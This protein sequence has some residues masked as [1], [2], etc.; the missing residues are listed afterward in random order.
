VTPASGSPS[1]HHPFCPTRHRIDAGL[2]ARADVLYSSEIQQPYARRPS[3]ARICRRTTLRHSTSNTAAP[4]VRDEEVSGRP[5][6]IGT[7]WA[8]GN[9]IIHTRDST[10]YTRDDG[11]SG[12][13]RLTS[14]H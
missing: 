1:T 8:A 11:W 10:G 13:R 7:R 4:V 9:A 14:C 3:W 6:T 5:W 2:D 12:S